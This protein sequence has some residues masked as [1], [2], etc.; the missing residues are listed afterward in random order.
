MRYRAVSA[1][2]DAGRFGTVPI[3]AAVIG[4]GAAK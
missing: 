2:P 1:F 3:D 4:G